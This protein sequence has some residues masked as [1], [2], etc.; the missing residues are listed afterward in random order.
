[1]ALASLQRHALFRFQIRDAEVAA[2]VR[3]LRALLGA[4]AGEPDAREL[5]GELVFELEERLENDASDVF[6]LA[7][8]QKFAQEVELLAD[9]AACSDLQR[10][11]TDLQL[12]PSDLRPKAVAKQVSRPIQAPKTQVTAVTEAKAEEDER[13]G[14]CGMRDSPE[15]DPIVLCEICGVAVHQT[16][17]R[18]DEL[19]EGD[20]L[21]QPCARYTHEQLAD[22]SAGIEPTHEIECQAC[23]TKGGALVPSSTAT[24]RD[25]WVHLVCTMFLPELYVLS[26]NRVALPGT[27]LAEQQVFGGAV[28]TMI[29][30]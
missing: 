16:C 7:A 4:A 13:C 9:D 6:L 19:P 23:L 5:L 11:P 21:C 30:F 20:W 22:G 24:A 29:F 3:E 27:G 17:Y 28:R 15:N 14:V 18:I 1:M 2:R 25:G 26:T 8:L 12:K 10:Q